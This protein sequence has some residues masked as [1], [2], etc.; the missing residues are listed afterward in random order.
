MT[1]GVAVLCRYT[2]KRLPGKILREING[3]AVL[4]HI[5]DRVRRGAPGCPVAVC[6]SSDRSDDPI[7]AYAK[8]EGVECFRGDLKDVSGRFLACAEA[9]G[10]E[11][12]ARINGDNVFADP[13]SLREMIAIAGTGVFDFVTNVPGRTFPY[14]M[15]IEIVRTDFYR[16][17]M[18]DVP[19]PGHHEHVTSWLYENPNLGRQYWYENKECPDA[20]GLQL[21][22]DTEADLERASKIIARMERA[23]ETYGLREIVNLA[24]ADD[25]PKNLDRY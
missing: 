5:L 22:L 19:D 1:I 4:G 18:E 16:Q 6:T 7:H 23:P 13:D 10:W 21:A 25:E 15:S 11:F 14:G 17:A 12:S 2:S 20:D 9:H 24:T 8:R 3:R